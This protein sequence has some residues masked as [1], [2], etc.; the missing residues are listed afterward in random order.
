M[1]GKISLIKKL[2]NKLKIPTF[3]TL[4]KPKPVLIPDVLNEI[5]R[6]LIDDRNALRSC[7]LVCR[8]WCRLVMPI[9][10][11]DPFMKRN[12][13]GYFAIRTYICCLDNYEKSL[14]RQQKIRIPKFPNPLFDYPSF[15]LVFNYNNF[16]IALEDFVT[17][18]ELD[19]LHMNEK[20]MIISSVIVNMIVTRS[21]GIRRFD[22]YRSHLTSQIILTLDHSLSLLGGRR[23]GGERTFNSLSRIQT[24]KFNGFCIKDEIYSVTWPNL[25]KTIS[26]STS[27]IQHLTFQ[28][29]KKDFSIHT[30]YNSIANL[31]KPQKISQE[32]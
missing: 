20:R 7:I 26:M 10:W 19:F 29:K 28:I 5:F 23:E 22:Y 9:L 8:L 21:K 25:F 17:G 15:L 13:Y 31:I 14:L 24:F 2:S 4:T 32:F 16:A 1:K 3:P 6:H 30:I 27:N 12:D 18:N 11:S